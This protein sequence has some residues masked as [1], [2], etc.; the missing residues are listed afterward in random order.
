MI[1]EEQP[2]KG[3]R[4]KAGK[5][6]SGCTRV[7]DRVATASAVV[8][9]LQSRGCCVGRKNMAKAIKDPT[10]VAPDGGWGWVIVASCFLT[11]VCTRAVTRCISILFVEFQFQFAKDYSTTAWIHSIVDCMTMLCA[12]LGS[13]IGNRL[14]HRAAVMLG[15]ILSSTGLVMSSFATSLEFLYLSLGI[16][17]GLGFALSYTPAVAMVGMYFSRRKAL[18]YGLAMSGSGIGTFVLAPV[19]Q[20]LIELYTWRGALLIL[21]GLVSHLCVCGALLKPTAELERR[22][23]DEVKKGHVVDLPVCKQGGATLTHTEPSDSK[24]I[25]EKLFGDILKGSGLGEDEQ[26]VVKQTDQKCAGCTDVRNEN[27][28]NTCLLPK[29]LER[30]QGGKACA[31]TQP[32]DTQPGSQEPPSTQVKHSDIAHVIHEKSDSMNTV[33]NHSETNQVEEDTT[34]CVNTDPLTQ[35]PP[36]T[37]VEHS[38]QA[39][40][41]PPGLV[42]VALKLTDGQLC[43]SKLQDAKPVEAKPLDKNWVSPIVPVRT[44]WNTRCRPAEGCHLCLPPTEEYAFLLMT[45]FLLL[46]VSFLFLA[47]GCSVPFV[48]VVPYALS[49]GVGHQQA[50]LLISI[51]G[52]ISIVGNVT[53]GWMTDWNCLRPYRMVSYMLAV[54]LE[55][56]SC[57]LVPLLQSFPLLVP[58]ALLYGYFD[59]AYVALIPVVTSDIVGPTY[60]SSALGVVYFLHAVPY[61]ISPPIGG[62][63]VDQTGSYMA[64]FILSGLSVMTSSVVLGSVC[65][66]RHC[67]RPHSGARG[68]G[69]NQMD[70]IKP[71][72]E[73]N[74]SVPAA[75]I[76]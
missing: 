48:Y 5:S 36:C 21:G 59:G 63:L 62:W 57:F 17:T 16:F 71:P 33:P 52:V 28:H 7:G 11:T 20:L 68:T 40:P 65:L 32:A 9:V 23:N 29:P 15:G 22:E 8:G 70:F 55:G 37:K 75:T 26:G 41:M 39:D 35:R 66:L 46:S 14:S 4:E 42:L 50:V 54:G 60:L 19:V 27:L 1:K 49:V 38:K 10:A 64:T 24:L 31:N 74:A 47:Y 56:F 3:E 44:G 51:M 69:S 45:D 73:Q 18:A 67:C 53:F 72:K 30:S 25:N 12:P 58:F 2:G 34:T 76:I 13:F 6:R 43:D 61:L